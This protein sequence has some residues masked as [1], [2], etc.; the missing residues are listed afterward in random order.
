MSRRKPKICFLVGYF[1]IFRGGAEFQSLFIANSLK[2]EYEIFFISESQQYIESSPFFSEEGFKIYVV[3][4]FNLPKFKPIYLI[5]YWK[6]KDILDREK[7]DIIYHRALNAGIYAATRYCKSTGAKLFW[8]AAII[9]DLFIDKIKFD[10][11]F[12]ISWLESKLMLKGIFSSDLI[13]TQTVEQ[14]DILFKKFGKDSLQ[15]YNF[16]PVPKEVAVKNQRSLKV[17]WIANLK[18]KKQPELFIKL[19]EIFSEV[20]NI[21]FIMMGKIQ[22]ERYSL[23]YLERVSSEL[24]NF[25]YLGEVPVETVN[26]NLFE[27]HILVNTSKS[28]G[29]SN[30]FVQAFFYKVPVV[31]LLV[32]PDDIL[33]NYELGFCTLTFDKMVDKITL[34][35]ENRDLLQRMG[36][37]AY[38]FA[39]ENLTIKNLDV[40]KSKFDD[41]YS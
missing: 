21:E 20:N 15:V 3:D 12:L 40:I 10:H 19:A 9:G 37:N 32:D 24:K 36:L 17:F 25:R 1:P 8:H 14:K 18:Q 6:I 16:L 29:F 39:M 27:G 13:F 26:S 31:S 35:N 11:N 41:Y 5:R 22:D 30:T 34:L 23:S 4:R 28:E 2:K 7:P 33:E 38:N